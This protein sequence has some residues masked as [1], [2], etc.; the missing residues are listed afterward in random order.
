MK[1]LWEL[2]TLTPGATLCHRRGIPLGLW[3]PKGPWAPGSEQGALLCTG[4]A[5]SRFLTGA[6]LRRWRVGLD[7][8]SSRVSGISPGIPELG[9]TCQWRFPWV[10]TLKVHVFADHS[11]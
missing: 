6:R 9:A 3:D 5:L 1:A 11:S 4:P 10:A 7:S 2:R 8:P